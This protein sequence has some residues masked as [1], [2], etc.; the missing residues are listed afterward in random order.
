MKFA[1]NE[2]KRL[3]GAGLYVCIFQSCAVFP[4]LYILV[5]SG[6]MSLMNTNSPFSVLSDMALSAMPR[7]ES[8]LLSCLYRLS[9]NEIVV[10]AA[11]LLFALVYGTVVSRY[12][13]YH[14]ARKLRIVLCVLIG[15]DLIIRLLPLSFNAIYGT[16]PAIIGFIVRLGCLVL[17]LLDLIADK[18]QTNS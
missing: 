3:T 1:V 2:R 17:I 15:A 5:L 14:S 12:L 9:M 7:A 6:Y 4:V 8:V 10:S 13:R 11:V 18:K 16:L